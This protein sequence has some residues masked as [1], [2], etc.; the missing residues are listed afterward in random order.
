MIDTWSRYYYKVA[1]SW[2]R[3]LS[4]FSIFVAVFYI[5]MIRFEKTAE[6]R[7]CVEEIGSCQPIYI[8]Y[9]LLEHVDDE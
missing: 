7:L 9:T 8:S 2:S 1:A 3:R 6:G 4:I 5:T